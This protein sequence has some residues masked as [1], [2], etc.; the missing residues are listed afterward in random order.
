MK[1]PEKSEEDHIR[2]ARALLIE[3]ALPHVPFDGWSNTTLEAAI[4]ESGVD[5]GLA[6][7]AFPRG[8]IDMA[9]A[10]HRQTDQR[11]ADE[12]AGADLAAMRIRDRITH[13][14]RRRIELVAE[15][16]EAVRR[17][18]ALLSLP[19]HAPEGAKAV[20]ET[21]DIIWNACGDTATDYNWYTKRIILSGVYSSAVLFWLGDT[22]YG[23]ANTWAFL[24][25]RIE[26]VMRFERTKAKMNESPFVRAAMWGPMQVLSG[27]RKP[28]TAGKAPV[29]P[30]D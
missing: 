4:A 28:G 5:A 29:S 3:A 9:L 20:W 11:L 21:A 19:I 22:S 24:D 16:R 26:D 13:C 12:L 15:N 30:A 2:E 6:R 14:V 25:R 7:Q 23:F 10:F 27:L 8:G 1:K 17:G 18:G